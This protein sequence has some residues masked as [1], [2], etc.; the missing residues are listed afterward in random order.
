MEAPFWT[1]SAA[2]SHAPAPELSTFPLKLAAGGER[3]RI[4][5]MPAVRDDRWNPR[6]V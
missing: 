6:S 4:P 1:S 3:Y 5:K 2:L